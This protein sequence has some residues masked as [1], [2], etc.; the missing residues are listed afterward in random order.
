MIS[1][2][3]KQLQYEASTT[4]DL[5]QERESACMEKVNLFLFN[6]QFSKIFF[7]YSYF[8]PNWT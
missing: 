2:A 3:Y 7:S 6:T 4:T 8:I 5:G 1:P